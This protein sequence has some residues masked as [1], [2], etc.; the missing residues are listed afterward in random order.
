MTLR[1]VKTLAPSATPR[2][3]RPR[4][5]NHDDSTSGSFRRDGKLP[6]RSVVLH[7]YPL[8]VLGERRL[9]GQVG[10]D[11]FVVPAVIRLVD[12]AATGRNRDRPRPCVHRRIGD[13][14]HVVVALAAVIE[15]ET[16]LD[17]HVV[18]RELA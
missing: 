16:L 18:A 14:R 8:V 12:V 1:V 9:A 7:A 2:P 15:D 4:S 10:L 6:E 17:M 3:G 11:A 5:E 13:R